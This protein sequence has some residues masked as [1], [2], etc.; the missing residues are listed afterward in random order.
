MEVCVSCLC[1]WGKGISSSG[2][3][4]MGY[5]LVETFLSILVQLPLGFTNHLGYRPYCKYGV[6]SWFSADGY[7]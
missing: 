5:G 3:P 7:L 2:L 4:E 1:A 6:I